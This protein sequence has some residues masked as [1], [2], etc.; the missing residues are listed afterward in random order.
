MTEGEAQSFQNCINFYLPLIKIQMIL[1]EIHLAPSF[2]A[3][4][5]ENIL[6]TF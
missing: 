1:L 5:D 3:P 4:Q 2:R 6:E